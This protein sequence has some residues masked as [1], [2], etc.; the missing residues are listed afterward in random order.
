MKIIVFTVVV[1]LLMVSCSYLNRKFSLQDDN[2][3]E[4]SVEAALQHHTG[5]DVDLTPESPE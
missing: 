2:L 1:S 3:I 5:L 4:E